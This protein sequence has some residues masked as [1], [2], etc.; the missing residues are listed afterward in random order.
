[1]IDEEA[2]AMPQGH[3]GQADSEVQMALSVIARLKQFLKPN[4]PITKITKDRLLF[5][6]D[7][8]TNLINTPFEELIGKNEMLKEFQKT[9]VSE[10]QKRRDLQD[11]KDDSYFTKDQILVQEVAKHNVKLINEYQ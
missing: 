10:F 3:V 1:M 8:R 2:T 6:T 7:L 11:S 5:D 4:S 9:Y